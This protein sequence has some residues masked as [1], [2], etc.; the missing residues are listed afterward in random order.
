MFKGMQ[1]TEKALKILKLS[2]NEGNQNC[3]TTVIKDFIIS[4]SWET[5]TMLD[6]CVVAHDH[7]MYNAASID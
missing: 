6:T 2:Y 1:I 3:R 4:G 7:A 5:V